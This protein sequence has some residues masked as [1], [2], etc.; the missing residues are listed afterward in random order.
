[1]GWDTPIILALARQENLEFEA[2]LGYIARLYLKKERKEK[3]RER[4]RKVLS[5]HR[6]CSPSNSLQLDS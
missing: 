1:V 5:E 2:S 6:L 3:R 4:E